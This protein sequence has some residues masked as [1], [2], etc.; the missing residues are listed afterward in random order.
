MDFHA[1]MDVYGCLMD[2][3]AITN[4][5][6]NHSKVL[7]LNFFQL[8]YKANLKRVPD[9]WSNDIKFKHTFHWGYNIPLSIE[10]NWIRISFSYIFDEPWIYYKLSLCVVRNH[11]YKNTSIMYQINKPIRYT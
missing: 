11:I 2:F 3:L 9:D 5:I 8:I 4:F 1:L 10:D 6:K 7:P